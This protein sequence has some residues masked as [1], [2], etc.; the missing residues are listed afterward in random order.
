MYRCFMASLE[1]SPPPPSPLLSIHHLPHTP[2]HTYP[3]LSSPLH[4]FSLLSPLCSSAFLSSLFHPYFSIHHSFNLFTPYLLPP[5]TIHLFLDT[6]LITPF[7]LYTS[8]CPLP[9]H[10]TFHIPPIQLLTFTL[11]FSLNTFFP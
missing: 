5:R 6:F 7:S 3:P 2:T 9:T 8:N 1:E 11:C 10:A 4:P